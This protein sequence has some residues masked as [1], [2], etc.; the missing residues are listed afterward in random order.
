MI[1]VNTWT[2][3]STEKDQ[4]LRAKEKDGKANT[5][6]VLELDEGI[7][8]IGVDS[9][10]R[11][12]LFDLEGKAHAYLYMLAEEPELAEERFYNAQDQWTYYMNTDKFWPDIVDLPEASRP[13]R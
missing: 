12:Q 3:L 1:I 9:Y 10:T 2:G 8:A 11:K 7:K 4:E 5:Y 6:L 13:R